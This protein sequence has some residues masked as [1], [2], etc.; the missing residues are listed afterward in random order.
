MTSVRALAT[1]LVSVLSIMADRTLIKAIRTNLLML[2]TKVR[3]IKQNSTSRQ[4]PDS[5]QLATTARLLI[6][7]SSL[8]LLPTLRAAHQP[9]VI[10]SLTKT[11]SATN[12]FIW[13]CGK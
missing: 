6:C 10:N 1:F 11:I 5:S 8:L 4:P 2:L 12:Y 3:Q 9:D 7:V 13:L